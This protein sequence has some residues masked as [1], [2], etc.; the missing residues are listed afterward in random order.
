MTS[1]TAEIF[2]SM[3]QL[4]NCLVLWCPAD[5]GFTVAP[6]LV[7]SRVHSSNQSRI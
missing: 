5:F 6:S 2:T 7:R 4:Y 3:L 1:D